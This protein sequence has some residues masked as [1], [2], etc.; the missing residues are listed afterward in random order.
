MQ[1]ADALLPGVEPAEPSGAA[2]SAARPLVI[3]P[4][5]TAPAD[6]LVYEFGA[7]VDE[8]C[9]AAAFEQ[10]QKARRLY[11]AVIGDLAPEKRIPC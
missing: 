5:I 1:L 11:N 10:I 9:K 3:E 8:N 7:R 6:V 2:A 4:W